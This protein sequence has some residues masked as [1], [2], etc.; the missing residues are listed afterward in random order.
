MDLEGWYSVTP[1]ALAR[2]QA[3]ADLTSLAGIRR[4]TAISPVD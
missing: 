4:D 3:G 2:H 1:E